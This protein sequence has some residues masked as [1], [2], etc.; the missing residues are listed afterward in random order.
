V[1]WKALAVDDVAIGK[2]PGDLLAGVDDRRRLWLR[3]RQGDIDANRLTHAA[4]SFHSCSIGDESIES[5][6]SVGVLEGRRPALIERV[7]ALA[8]IRVADHPLV[9]LDLGLDPRLER[10]LQAHPRRPL[11]LLHRG[12]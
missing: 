1:R 7:D 8:A 4:A 2:L 9:A 3:G 5:R 12:R 11:R 6:R 10:E